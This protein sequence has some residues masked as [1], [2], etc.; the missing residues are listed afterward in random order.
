[1]IPTIITPTTKGIVIDPQYELIKLFLTN[2]LNQ[3]TYLVNKKNT[4]ENFYF[5]RIDP[6]VPIVEKIHIGSLVELEIDGE[7]KQISIGINTPGFE[8]IEK[9]SAKAK[10]LFS[11]K[12]GEI[13]P[14]YGIK[15]KKIF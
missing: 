9:D 2:Q 6:D 15:I 4:P 12:E 7:I 3:F 8:F 14:G 1:L 10:L 13:V 5:N 11:R